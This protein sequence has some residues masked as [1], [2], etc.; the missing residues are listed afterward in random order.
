MSAAASPR[1]KAM[2]LSRAARRTEKVKN[3]KRK[4]K[5]EEMKKRRKIRFG[6]LKIAG[7]LLILSFLA[8]HLSLSTAEAHR[9]HTSLT[10]IDYNE[11]EKL[12]EIS[13]QVFTHDLVPA[14]EQKARKRI[15]LEKTPDADRLIQ[16]YL[17]ENFVLKNKNGDAEKLNWIGKQLEVDSVWLYFEIPWN[18]TLEGANLQNSLF[19]EMFPEQANLVV[20]RFAGKKADLVF[21][22]GDKFKEIT[23]N[24]PKD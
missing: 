10:R 3:E 13:M 19:F 24:K 23:E 1:R 9:Y 6:A 17:A 15:D 11:K 12:L 8:L 4:V 22:A 7:A 2:Q 18:E 16:D 20:A 5:S 21:K 14:L